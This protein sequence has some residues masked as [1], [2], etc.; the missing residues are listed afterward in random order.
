[1]W[2]STSTMILINCGLSYSIFIHILC[3]KYVSTH[4]PRRKLLLYFISLRVAKLTF[5]SMFI[6][7]NTK[8]F[9]VIVSIS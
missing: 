3:H 1:M 7:Q 9:N 5:D 6:K 8:Y 4:V 2:M